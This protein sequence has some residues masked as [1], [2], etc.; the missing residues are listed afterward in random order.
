MKQEQKRMIGHG[1]LIL[2]IGMLAGIGL[3][4]SLLG[5]IEVI[6]GTII[7]V[8][9][10][11]TS[12]GWVRAHIGSM[13]NGMLIILVA[14]VIHAIGLAEETA[15][16]LR[17]MLIGTGYANTLFYA[18]ALFAPN[19]ALSFASNRLGTANLASIIGLAPALIFAVISLIAVFILMKSAFASART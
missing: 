15:R 7:Q 3:L 18:A 17:W 4:V 11:G 13:L 5:G 8:D 10:P 14:L 19:R 6:P 16:N 9:I 12:A 1:A 2:L